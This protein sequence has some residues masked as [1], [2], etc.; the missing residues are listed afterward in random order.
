[1]L[2]IRSSLLSKTPSSKFYKPYVI[3]QRS[4][5]HINNGQLVNILVNESPEAVTFLQEHGIDLS[6]VVQC[7]GHS[8][9]VCISH[10]IFQAP[11]THRQKPN[12]AKVENVGWHIVGT[13]MKYLQTLPHPQMRII[14]N[15]KVDRLLLNNDKVFIFHV[16]KI[17]K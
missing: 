7:G 12:E 3:I 1:M 17:N 15:A 6:V 10:L 2:L 9:S 13:L 4:G 5:G 16:K 8:V 11:R 14:N